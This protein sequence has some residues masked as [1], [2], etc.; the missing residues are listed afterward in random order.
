MSDRDEMNAMLA[1]ALLDKNHDAA[2]TMALANWAA[3][4]E[5]KH[6]ILAISLLRLASLSVAHM[7]E[8]DKPDAPDV[9]C[10]V[11]ETYA[12]YFHY[13]VYVGQQ[14]ITDAKEK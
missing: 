5:V 11:I 8:S 1:T 2:L 4:Q 6:S 10:E 7:L 12:D 14:C 9:V 13:Y 3:S